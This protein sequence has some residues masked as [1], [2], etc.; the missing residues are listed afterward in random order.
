MSEIVTLSRRDM[1]AASLAGA[2]FA[3][4]VRSSDVLAAAAKP[5]PDAPATQVQP[6]MSFYADG[7]AEIVALLP[8]MGQGV[9]T[10]LPL[11]LA[12]ELDIDWAK[13]SIRL[14]ESGM[15]TP[16]VGDAGM[17]IAAS[18]RSV[19][20]WYTPLRECGARA[21]AMIVAAAAQRW[22]VPAADCRTELGWVIHPRGRKR[23]SYGELA[24]AAAAQVPPGDVVLKGEADFRL[25]GKTS[26]RRDVMDKTTGKTLFASDIT[27]PGMLYASVA[28]PPFGGAALLGYD[29]DAAL[30]L[31]RVRNLFVIDDA[32]LVAVAEDSWSAMRA[33]EAAAPRFEDKADGPSSQAYADAL[34]RGVKAK[35]R[36]W[37]V[38]GQSAGVAVVPAG[39]PIE[40]TYTL[41]YLAHATMEP[42]SCAAWFRGDSCELWAPTQAVFAA[43]AVAAKAAG[44]AEDAVLVRQTFLGGGFGRRSE[45]DFVR[46]AVLISRAVKG[47]I[48]LQWSRAEDMKHDYYRP[49]YA[50]RCTGAAGAGGV[51]DYRVTTAGP[52]ILRGRMAIFSGPKAPIDPTTQNGLLPG[53]Y[54]L[55]N[56]GAQWVEVPSAIPTSYWRSV[57]HSQ[58]VFAAECFI[59]ELAHAA[60][61]DP[62]DFRQS[63]ITDDRMMAVVAKLRSLSDWDTPPP[64]GRA[65]GIGLVFCYDSY[66]GQVV[67]V[68][69]ENG[70]VRVHRVTSVVDCGVAVQPANVVAQIEGGAIFG[71]SAGLYGDITVD[72][73]VVAQSSFGDYRVLTLSETPAMRTHVMSTSHAPGGVGETGTPACAPAL[74]NAL[75][76]L[77]GRRL[78]D[79][80]LARAFAPAT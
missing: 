75:F 41:P 13:V 33:L 31:P 77:T 71:I 21:R 32:T 64:A 52:S 46:Q 51:T 70:D 80:P 4:G 20:A 66:A 24:A 15:A 55:P 36:E 7:R 43:R 22:K 59:D 10:T 45:S 73:G 17:L 3:L 56:S 54:N 18:S 5:G 16:P 8:D 69:V 58:N 23:L 30:A 40:A 48:R 57:A 47:P 35:G 72:R 50:M 19:R 28:Q 62:M 65:R 74:A 39:K 67:E 9:Y 2:V 68:S 79:L 34:S 25:I 29:R 26:D 37:G 61:A 11:I 6:L 78:R 44:L 53:F 1:I 49:A 60:G 14:F 76:A 42:M 63:L 27:L 12:E 38:K